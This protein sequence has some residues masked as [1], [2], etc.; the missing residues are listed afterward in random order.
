MML[1]E[2]D[3]AWCAGVMDTMGLVKI[4]TLSNGTLLPLVFFHSTKIEI[5]EKLSELAGGKVTIVNKSYVRSP[6]V[7]HCQEPH[8][9]I[10]STSGR[11]TISGARALIFLSGVEPFIRVRRQE[12][13]EVIALGSAA[14]RKP[15]TVEKMRE[16]GWPIAEL[17]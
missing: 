9:H 13:V 16:M 10:S 15:A 3:L 17:K 7:Q 2:T 6:C 12:I 1:N 11:W 5:L 8:V 14:P 4:R